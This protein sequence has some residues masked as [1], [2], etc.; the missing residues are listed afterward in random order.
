MITNGI[1]LNPSGGEAAIDSGYV[2]H[3]QQCD[4]S[5]GEILVAP[6]TTVAA[7]LLHGRDP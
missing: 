7:L 6:R 4:V 3:R 2:Q 5:A 1:A